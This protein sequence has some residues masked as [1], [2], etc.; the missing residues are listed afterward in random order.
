MP[1]LDKNR[2]EREIIVFDLVPVN[3][4]A[5]SVKDE[6]AAVS[7]STPASLESIEELRAAAYEAA[8]TSTPPARNGEAKRTW[9]ERSSKVRNY[10]LARAKGVCEACDRDAP[11]RKRDG[12]PY[13]EPHHTTRLADEGLDHPGSVG[14]ICPT[15]HRRIHSGSDG[16]EWNRQL[17]IRVKIKESDTHVKLK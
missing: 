9:Y 4:A 17:Q 2:D 11:F 14:A 6:A 12:T 8:N 13:L 15:C 5:A 1:G 7:E 16:K 3:T 10:V